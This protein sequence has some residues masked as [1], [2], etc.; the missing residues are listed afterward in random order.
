MSKQPTD[1]KAILA[2]IDF[3]AKIAQSKPAGQKGFK[4]T[5]KY[6]TQIIS[7]AV[8]VLPNFSRMLDTYGQNHKSLFSRFP[9]CNWQGA[10][11]I[12][13]ESA[14]E[15]CAITSKGGELRLSYNVQGEW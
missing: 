10:N 4:Y 11:T 13:L 12:I 3:A 6:N 14:T 5:I 15:F 2:A 7:R 8:Q 9:V 1:V